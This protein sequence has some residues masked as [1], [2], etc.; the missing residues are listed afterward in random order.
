MSERAKT[1][2]FAV[3]MVAIAVAVLV[4][5]QV[6]DNAAATARRIVQTGERQQIQA[7]TDVYS[8]FTV[9]QTQTATP[10]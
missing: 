5:I 8:T 9:Q 7:M 2:L 10:K 1:V 3:V 4:L 6:N